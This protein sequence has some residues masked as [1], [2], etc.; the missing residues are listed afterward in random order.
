MLFTYRVITNLI[1]LFTPIIFL[2][3]LLKK[4]EDPKRFKE[5][6]CFFSKRRGKGKLIWFH[7]ASVG[8][9]LSVVPLIQEL[10]KDKSVNKILITSNTLS[11]LKVINTLSLKKTIHQFFPID[12]LFFVKKFLKY[13]SPSVAIFIDSEIW[14]NMLTSIKQESISLILLNA[15]IN[16]RSFKK[17]ARLGSSAKKLFNKFDLCLTS[18]NETKIHLKLLGAKNIKY[19]GNLK[20][21]ESESSETVLNKYSKKFFL[22]KK[23]WCASSTHKVEEK[24]SASVHLMLKKKYK[25]ILT[26][27][28]PRHINRIPEIINELEELDLKIHLH[29]SRDKIKNN[30]DIYLVDAYGKTK[31][32]FSICNIVF[33]GGSLI[34]HGGQNPLEAARYNCQ[35][36]HGPN[37]WNFREIYNLLRRLKVSQKITNIRQ[38]VKKISIILNN[39]KKNK[40]IQFKLNSLSKNILKLTLIEINNQ[41]IK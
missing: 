6:F 13:W 33:L 32:F 41:I 22:S 34:G 26:I 37:I 4:K 1:I 8:E 18:S 17:W 19:I 14:P 29:S 21:T 23:I 28:I 24:I 16:K 27:I 25:N 38:I 30:T 15:R 7:G 10:E 31:M 36:L 20:F 5:K 39:K 3:R 11:S 12:N 35:I 2:I 9:I 40:D